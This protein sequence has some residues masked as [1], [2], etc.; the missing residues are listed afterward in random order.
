[1]TTHDYYLFGDYL[2]FGEEVVE[3]FYGGEFVVFDVEDGVELGDV[4]D[5]LNFLG[6]AEELEFAASVADGG[7]A[8]DQFAD[9]GG[10]DVID[11]G[12]IEDDFFLALGD[13]LADGVAEKSGFVAESDASGNVDDGNV[14]DIASGDGHWVSFQFW[15]LVLA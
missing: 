2:L 8:A 12:E 3:G 9:A 5:V 13:E 14:A 11:V 1:V 7:E 6:E 15:F 10:I 4:E